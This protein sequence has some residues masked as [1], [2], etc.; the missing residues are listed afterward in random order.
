MIFDPF[1]ATI[2]DLA[3]IMIFDPFI[4]TIFDL[5]VAAIFDPS[6]PRSS[7]SPSP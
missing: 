1:I 6:S 7:T 3:V 5:A 2:F 4:A